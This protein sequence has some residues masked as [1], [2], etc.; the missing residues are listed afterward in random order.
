MFDILPLKVL[1]PVQC[2]RGR[3]CGE[4]L[5]IVTHFADC[6]QKFSGPFCRLNKPRLQGWRVC[7]VWRNPSGRVGGVQ[8]SQL[9][10]WPH[11]RV[12]FPRL[13]KSRANV[14]LPLFI[15]PKAFLSLPVSLNRNAKKKEIKL[16]LHIIWLSIIITIA[17]L[18]TLSITGTYFFWAVSGEFGSKIVSSTSSATSLVV[19]SMKSSESA[20][21]LENRWL[22]SL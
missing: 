18:S 1:Q 8:G 21:S 14:T 2:A 15:A 12:H 7:W 10:H 13:L 16:V 20:N 4:I 22:E 9:Q 5:E 19:P 17:L 6:Y 3:H 11:P